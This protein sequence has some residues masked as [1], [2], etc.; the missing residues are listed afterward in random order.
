MSQK[1]RVVVLISGRG[2]N[3]KALVAGSRHAHSAYDVVGVIANVPDA[4]GLLWAADEGLATR[5][6]NHRD[7]KTRTAFETV[8]HD[9]VLA[10]QPDFIALAGFMRILGDTFVA[11]WQGRMLNIHP[12]LLPA[13]KGLHTHEQAIAARVKIAGCTVHFVT[14]EMDAGP[15]IAQAAVAVMP[16]DTAETLA[17]RILVAEHKIY[18]AALDR[19]CRGT[20]TLVA[21]KVVA[22]PHEAGSDVNQTAVLYSPNL[23]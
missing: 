13:F 5:V 10:F 8:L 23:N 12:S 17:E 16:T 3:M 1:K 14:P 2:S 9:T 11:N 18:P 20:V 4:A 7:F 22:T 19:V 15:I 6:V 21:G